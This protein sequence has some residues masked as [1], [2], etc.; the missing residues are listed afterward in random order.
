[1]LDLLKCERGQKPFSSLY[2]ER[3]KRDVN[4]DSFDV[5]YSS[6]FDD[7][8]RGPSTDICLDDVESR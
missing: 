1:M 8:N 7:T 3:L 2:R 4:L 5:S 6:K